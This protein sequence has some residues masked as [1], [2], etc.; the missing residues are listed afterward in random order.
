MDTELG[1]EIEE[2]LAPICQAHGVELVDV[3]KLRE[4]SGLV[5]RI[6]LDRQRADGGDGSGI[7]LDDCT[8]VSRDASAALDVRDDLLSG[9]YRLEVS[10]PGPE[11]PLA[12]RAD[13]E[14]FAGRRVELRARR[15]VDGRRKFHGTLLG[16][17]DDNIRVQ[18][19]EDILE[20]PWD[21][22]TR[23]HLSES[24]D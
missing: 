13:F 23:A 4:P 12:R 22:I 9:R 21:L 2:V 19:G 14:R 6:I 1:T 18:E 15:P 7:T 10:S 24:S 3:R 16:V 20:V 11:R 5:L 8:V 17:E